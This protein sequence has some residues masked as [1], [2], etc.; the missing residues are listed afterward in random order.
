MKKFSKILCVFLALIMCLSLGVFASDGEK[1]NYVVLGDSIGW[2]AGVI[3]SSEAVFGKIVADTNGYNF[4]NDAVNGYTTSDLL[5]HLDKEK[6]AA[7][8]KA[9]D[10]ISVSIGGNNF[11]RGDMKS[12]IAEAAEG[13]YSRFDDIAA[14]FYIEFSAIIEKIKALNPDALILAQTLY[15][16]GADSIKAVYQQGA[17]RLNAGYARYLEENPGA[18]ELLEVAKPFVGHPEYVA[19]DYIHPSAKGNEVI[20]KI[21]LEKLFELGLGESTE[22]V[23]LHEGINQTEI[24]SF[25]TVAYLFRLIAARF[26]AMLEAIGF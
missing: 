14:N 20:A 23:I 9:A 22:P 10:I 3:N 19:A 25:K 11:L 24:F 8:V 15:N 12:L 6:I 4:K 21:V 17:D 1:L 18:Y 13:N 7:D 26:T 5:K 2:G 16:P